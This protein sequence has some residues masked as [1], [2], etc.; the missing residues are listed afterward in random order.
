M[1][2]KRT[3]RIANDGTPGTSAGT[4]T[5]DYYSMW[6]VDI[7]TGVVSVPSTKKRY[8]AEHAVISGRAGKWLFQ[9]I[10]QMLV[11]SYAQNK[12]ASS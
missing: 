9:H 8:E 1:L 10:Y 12:R 11:Q 2:A 3:C 4:V 6:A 7:S 5:L